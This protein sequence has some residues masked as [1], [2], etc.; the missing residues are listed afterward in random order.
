MDSKKSMIYFRKKVTA[1]LF[2]LCMKVK[3]RYT[4]VY[5]IY[6]IYK[7]MSVCMGRIANQRRVPKWQPFKNNK[8]GHMC[9]CLRNVKFLCLTL[10]QGQ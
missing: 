8:S 5:S 9:I 7:S 6:S 10:W 3:N 2:L 4:Y 1:A